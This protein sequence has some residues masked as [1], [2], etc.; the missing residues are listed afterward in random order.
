MFVGCDKLKVLNI[1]NWNTSKVTNMNCLFGWCHSLTSMDLS[2]WDVSSVV[3]MQEMFIQCTSLV[4]LNLSNW[5]V[6]S[7]K[8]PQKMFKDCYD[9]NQLDISNWVLNENVDYTQ[10]FEFC[11][12]T[13]KNSQPCE[14][15]ATQEAQKILLGKKE[16]TGMETEWFIWTNGTVDNEGSDI[17]DMPNQEW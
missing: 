5:D 17:E 13:L 12:L 2:L 14:I 16:T 4:S 9:L 3:A 8:E 15:T 1:S 10:M 6:S 7:L 11:N